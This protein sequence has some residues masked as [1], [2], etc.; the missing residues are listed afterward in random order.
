M[1]SL[2]FKFVSISVCEIGEIIQQNRTWKARKEIKLITN[3]FKLNG[4]DYYR[5]TEE[6]EG[7]EQLQ[8]K[9]GRK[10][11]RPEEVKGKT[12]I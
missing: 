8:K 7:D 1:D 10:E 9:E 6:K 3:I 2:S 11:G 5:W 12:G 4:F